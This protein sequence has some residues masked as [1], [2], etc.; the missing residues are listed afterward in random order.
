M[1]NLSSADIGSLNA[2]FAG[3]KG[4]N[5]PASTKALLLGLKIANVV[6]T[7][8]LVAAKGSLGD[9]I[10]L[11]KPE[12]QEQEP[13][14]PEDLDREGGEA[15]AGAAVGSASHGLPQTPQTPGPRRNNSPH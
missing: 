8:I 2:D 15:L 9:S 12:Q 14:A 5:I 10:L 4:E 1:Q 11:D 3:L 6:S 13:S 7:E